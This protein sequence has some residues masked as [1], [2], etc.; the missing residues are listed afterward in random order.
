MFYLILCVYVYCR[1]TGVCR[2]KLE[3]HVWLYV[4]I[5]DS[6]RLCDS[7]SDTVRDSM[8]DSMWLYV[9]MGDSVTIYVTPRDSMC[10]S[11]YSMWV[12]LWL[13]MWL[14]V[15]LRECVTLQ[16]KNG[17]IALWSNTR[18]V[19]CKYYVSQKQ[20]EFN[21]KIHWYNTLLTFIYKFTAGL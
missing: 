12:T 9:T 11:S 13:G 15:N 20:N 14:Y 4:T 7:K 6:T 21:N 19:K 17:V 2:V 5:C 3:S 10:D 16:P 8:C 1:D 18:V